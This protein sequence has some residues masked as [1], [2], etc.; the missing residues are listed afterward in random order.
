[1]D[2]TT[3]SLDRAWHGIKRGMA[4]LEHGKAWIGFAIAAST[5]LI[6]WFLVQMI[7]SR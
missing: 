6:S 4:A 7:V 2:T 5:V 1:V 3:E